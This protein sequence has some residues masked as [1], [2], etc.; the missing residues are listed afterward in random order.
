[1]EK[2]N[3]TIDR[4]PAVA[5]KFYPAKAD[6]LEKE[7]DIF[8][9]NAVPKQLE[10]VRAI[11]CPHAGYVFSGKIAA[12][13]FNQIDRNRTYKR[14]FLIGSSHYKYFDKASVYCAGN[15]LMPYGEEKVDTDFGRKLVIN[16]PEWFT[17]D[18]TPHLNEH[19]LEGQLPFLHHVLRK[20]YV[21]VPI[22]IGTAHPS[23]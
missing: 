16:F 22:L 17:D 15:F 12:S 4:K 6:E 9:K 18:P 3:K 10:R 5:G 19:C 23:V 11:I 1:M 20:N 13:A 14:I 21:I 7:V 8:F 2:F